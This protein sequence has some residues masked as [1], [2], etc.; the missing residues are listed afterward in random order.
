MRR[1]NGI[2]GSVKYGDIGETQDEVQTLVLT[3]GT[4][5]GTFRVKYGGEFTGALAWNVSTADL[6]TALRGL[7][8][9][10]LNA[11]VVTG[12]PGVAYTVTN[13]DVGLDL[14]E[15]VNDNTTDGGVWEGGIVV[16]RTQAGGVGEVN[17]P[18]KGFDFTP[19]VPADDATTNAEGGFTNATAGNMKGT[20]SVTCLWDKDLEGEACPTEVAAGQE[21]TLHLHPS[22]G[23]GYWNVPALI[24][25]VPVRVTENTTTGWTFNFVNRGAFMWVPATA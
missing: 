5:G 9:T 18:I 20:G 21:V 1:V 7:A 2:T 15:V 23:G 11:V 24:T 13:P 6:Q 25:D 14:L 19:S 3:D 8:E 16:T 17:I 12:T 4:D 10:D 22:D